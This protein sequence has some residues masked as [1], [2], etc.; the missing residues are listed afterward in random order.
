[1]P[2]LTGAGVRGGQLLS[3][4]E[5]DQT[6]KICT[7]H[8][9]E[10]ILRGLSR[11]RQMEESEQYWNYAPLQDEHI[12][13][14]AFHQSPSSIRGVFGGNRSGKTK[15]GTMEMIWWATG[16]HPYQETPKPPLA[17]RDCSVDFLNG[18]YKITIP[19]YQ[20]HV[21]R[22][23]LKGG[24]WEAA[25]H[26]EQRVLHFKNGSFIEFM[27][28]DQPV[29]KAQ[30]VARDLVRFDEKPPK[31]HFDEAKMRCMDRNG[32]IILTMTPVDGRTWVYDEIAQRADGQTI[33]VFFFDTTRNPYLDQEAVAEII[34]G[35]SEEEREIRLKG[36]FIPKTGRIWPFDRG[37]HVKPRSH[38]P[39]DGTDWTALD[40][41]T[42][43]ESAVLWARADREGNLW[44]FDYFYEK[45]PLK[46][47]ADAFK[48]ANKEHDR[49]PYLNVIDH[50]ANT[51]D[52]I[53]LN[54]DTI[55]RILHREHGV[56]TRLAKKAVDPGI[57]AVEEL[58]GLDE[59]YHKPRVFFTDNMTEPIAQIEGYVWDD[60]KKR[61]D[62]DPKEKPLKRY[63]HFCD[64]LRYIVMQRPRYINPQLK[65][66]ARMRHVELKPLPG[67]GRLA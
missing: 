2:E 8:E 65:R 17:L 10:E 29:T 51:K 28:Y 18:I 66:M 47:V 3:P 20:K 4:R 16:T 37:L 44:C 24:S 31:D 6:L 7:P 23:F 34:N 63:D 61:T 50:N 5:I 11:L 52:H 55:R 54:G 19:T 14:L 45:A 46:L 38:L 43:T 1:M 60:W 67:T 40:V 25:Y 56:Y 39:E 13:Q 36:Q 53:T 62:K 33:S 21:P 26:K 12:N 41:H 58:M 49:D 22:K 35:L 30:G 48:L 27:S 32:R 59:V 64:C 42:R 57:K 15:V 9:R